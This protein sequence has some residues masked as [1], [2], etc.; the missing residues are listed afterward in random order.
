MRTETIVVARE[1]EAELEITRV[2]FRWAHARDYGDWAALADCFHEDATIHIGWMSGPARDYVSRTQAQ[3]G[4]RTAGAHA[5]HVVSAPLIEVA[6][7]RA[8]SICHG[9]LYV[10][11]KVGGVEVDIE[12]WMRFF[13]LLERRGGRWAIVKRTGVYEKDRMTAVD[14][15]GFPEGFWEGIDLAAFP[16]AKRFLCFAQVKNGS[17]PN[18]EFVSVHSAAEVALYEEGRRWTAGV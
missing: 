2:L 1:L 8:F 11:R 17:K 10:R 15:K 3:A 14:P 9:T 6:G 12:S 16:P 4:W 13:D 5:K 18:T 7:A